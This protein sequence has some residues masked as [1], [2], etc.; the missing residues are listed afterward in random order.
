MMESPSPHVEQ[1]LK[2][3]H[4]TYAI[5]GELK[6]GDNRLFVSR[7]GLPLAG[8]TNLLTSV[9]NLFEERTK[10]RSIIER[11]SHP[12][13]VIGGC[14]GIGKTRALVEIGESLKELKSVTV[15]QWCESI[16]I[17]Y[18]NGNP[19]TC[20]RSLNLG[21]Y[22]SQSVVA[23]KAFALRL[24]YFA[25]VVGQSVRLS[26]ESFTTVFP[27]NLLQTLT[28]EMSIIAIRRYCSEKSGKVDGVLYVGVDE[29][30]YLLDDNLRG[31]EMRSF[32]KATMIAFGSI[33]LPIDP[34]LLVFGIVA[35]T[36]V[37]PL[38]QV[39]A[40]SGHPIVKLPIGLLNVESCNSIMEKLEIEHPIKWN[41]WRTCRAFRT[42][43]S[44]FACL[45]RQ[46]E[47]L[48]NM[49]EKKIDDG[50]Q[51]IDLDYDV[52]YS[53][54]LASIKSDKRMILYARQLISAIILSTV[55]LRETYILGLGDASDCTY[56]ELEEQGVIT[57]KTSEN[58]DC[59][60]Q[61]PFSSFRRLLSTL[62]GRIDPVIAILRDMCSIGTTGIQGVQM[63]WQRFEDLFVQMEVVREILLSRTLHEDKSYS[64]NNFYCANA[65]STSMDELLIFSLRESCKVNTSLK[66]FPSSDWRSVVD[67]QGLDCS[68]QEI[69]ADTQIVKNAK[70]ALF[71]SFTSRK[72]DNEELIFCFGQQKFYQ[73][74]QLT[75]ADINKEIKKVSD[76]MTD[77]DAG[78]VDYVLIIAATRVANEEVLG[79]IPDKCI[80]ITGKSLYNF[81]SPIFAGRYQLYTEMNAVN[82]NT[83]NIS[84]IKT[85][86]GIGDIMS[87]AIVRRRNG[88]SFTCWNNLKARIPTIRET[89]Q[90]YISF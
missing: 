66:R 76:R 79:N 5:G 60:V 83:A 73:I 80:L 11:R 65:E 63:T 21:Y 29:I 39:F 67:C 14:S 24:L 30:N 42:C 71:D 44:D 49:I 72:K 31:K 48:L 56:G 18:N 34:S 58:G 69:K 53:E 33:M 9:H 43:W 37:M 75:L 45:P 36:T 26:F 16:V 13:G 15:N 85:I 1:I 47:I 28:T 64:V 87:Q 57:L 59:I 32:L 38:D 3:M 22:A 90:E 74:T 89:C 50:E 68:A 46:A 20:D 77:V 88:E 23:N 62:N 84:E 17:S 2:Y 25:F 40:E 55:V 86:P 54:L 41:N 78:N 12:V 61:L 6:F 7:Y 82:I 81:F 8:R 35:G 52:I 4:D 19:P 27:L 70:G 10:N 51:L